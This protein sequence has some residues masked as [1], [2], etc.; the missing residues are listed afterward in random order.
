MWSL[1]ALLAALLWAFSNVW[2]RWLIKRVS[3]GWESLVGVATFSLFSTSLL[4]ALLAGGSFNSAYLGPAFILVGVVWL[5]TM[6]YYEALANAKV[7]EAAPLLALSTIFALA[8]DYLLGHS[9]ST[10]QLAGV[11]LAFVGA[12]L[13]A[14]QGKLKGVAFALLA[15]LAIAIRNSVPVLFPMDLLD[16]IATYS[17]LGLLLS[18][19]LLF[20]RKERGAEAFAGPNLLNG[21][22]F[23]FFV[24]SL[25]NGSVAVSTAL[26]QLSALFVVL[27][28]HV[29][30]K[31]PARYT[32]TKALGALLLALGAIL[33]LL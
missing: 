3:V 25:L 1:L 24:L 11:A 4:F 18:I 12:F 19:P 21:L 28:A 15:A 10:H 14:W 31:A 5:L 32:L 29:I 33:C 8:V 2:D 7:E 13:I 9:L 6:F 30:F 16:F 20:A 22:A 26:S 27:I 17:F 23:A